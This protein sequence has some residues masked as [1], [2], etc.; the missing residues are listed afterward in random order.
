MTNLRTNATI[1]MR[2]RD[3]PEDDLDEIL[4]MVEI[5][6]KGVVIEQHRFR[7]EENRT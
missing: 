5:A 1:V 3:I 4:E 7:T 2:I 6:A